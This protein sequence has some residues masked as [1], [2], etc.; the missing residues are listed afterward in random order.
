MAKGFS[1]AFQVVA[2]LLFQV[3]FRGWGRPSLPYAFAFTRH[4]LNARGVSTGAPAPEADRSETMG[5]IS[6]DT[7][8]KWLSP[9]AAAE[10]S[11]VS[12]SLVYR[13]C[14]DGSLP[15][16]RVGGK[17]RRGKI[18]IAPADLDALLATFRVEGDVPVTLAP[19][20]SSSQGSSSPSAGSFSELKMD[21]LARAWKNR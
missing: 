13:W 14:S 17:G 8:P 18:L 10:R 21:R 19:A 4:V 5:A 12:L 15:H 11:C 6:P 3:F 1:Q 9:K 20:R 7:E 2:T 16:L